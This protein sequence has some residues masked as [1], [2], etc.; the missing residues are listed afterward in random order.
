[1]SLQQSGPQRIKYEQPCDEQSVCAFPAG[2]STA[3]HEA[4]EAEKLKLLGMLAAS[5]THDLNNPLCGVQSV[6]A[7]FARK[8]ELSEAER[9]LL[10][11][12][13]AQCERMKN[14]L[15]DVQEFI[16]AAP[17]DWSRFDLLAVLAVV[18][19]L[20]HK[21]CKHAQITVHP[22]ADT[23]PL[24]LTGCESQI[25]QLFLHICLAA[26][27]ALAGCGGEMSFKVLPQGN[28]V[29]LAW[30]FQVPPEAEPQL[31]NFFAMF[32]QMYPILDSGPGMAHAVIKLHGGA[33][34][35]TKFAQGEGALELSF[36]VERMNQ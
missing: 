10:N 20:V 35:P 18:L 27:G 32:A 2:T 6:L 4:M 16:H 30:Q 7:R 22:L 28:V 36:P 12:A 25:K 29:S 19:R 24:M 9:T 8:N 3:P 11:L 26:C 14:Q 17:E 23:G 21:P 5:L 13:L 33:M 34:H 31:A 1:V 15:K